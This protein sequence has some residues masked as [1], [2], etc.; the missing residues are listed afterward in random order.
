MR[1]VI[2]LLP[3]H[4]ATVVI[5]PSWSPYDGVCN[6]TNVPGRDVITSYMLAKHSE[7]ACYFYGYVVVQMLILF[8]PISIVRQSSL[9]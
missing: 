9:D 6:K 2:I 4:E 7:G 1:E 3:L 5:L 8:P